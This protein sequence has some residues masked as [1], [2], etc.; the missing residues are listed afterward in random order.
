MTRPNRRNHLD[1]DAILR[2]V[3]DSTDLSAE[4]RAHL[5]MCP[6]C[7]REVEELNGTL[8]RLGEKARAEITLVASRPFPVD[9]VVLSLVSQTTTLLQKGTRAVTPTTHRQITA[10]SDF[11]LEAM[12][13]VFNL[14][15][16]QVAVEVDQRWTVNDPTDYPDETPPD[17][18]GTNTDYRTNDNWGQPLVYSNPRNVRLGVKFSF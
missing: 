9:R 2:F 12:L 11:R 14:F 3:V 6:I 8:A 18:E 1:E 5:D 13:D 17:D 4:E 10:G 16:K 15:D 7:R